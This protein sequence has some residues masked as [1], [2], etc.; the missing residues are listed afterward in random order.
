MRKLVHYFASLLILLAVTN[1]TQAQ[2]EDESLPF[3]IGT[4]TGGSSEGIY[5]S[6][7]SLKDGSIQKPKL[8]ATV[9]NPSFLTVHP[10]LDVLY[11]VSEVP[12]GDHQV[13]AFR[14]GENMELTEL[15]HSKAGGNGPCYI[16]TD[17][18]GNVVL[19]AN[20]GSG[21]VTS[22]QLDSEGAFSKIT[23]NIQHEG[24]SVHPRQKGPHAHCIQA[25]GSNAYVC[26]V[27]LGL[28]QVIVYKLNAKTGEISDTGNPLTVAGGNG[29]RHLAFHPDGKH[30]FVIH[31]LNCKL[32]TCS[33]DAESG[34]LKE[35]EVVSTLPGDFQKGFSTAEVLVHPNGKFVYGSNR[36]HHSIAAFRFDGGKLASIGHTS[37][38]G[39][40]PRNFRIDPTGRFLLAEN[41]GTDSIVVFEIDANTGKLSSTGHKISV[42]SPCCIKFR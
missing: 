13:I 34:E 37:T 3:F 27:D 22:I 42:G 12:E 31:E 10:K 40:T 6:S 21:S 19:V 39:E 15:S 5:A 2:N 1:V 4:Y 16:A 20:Y 14:I 35:L 30:A 17:Q 32:S 36:G 18:T 38:K 8:V 25:D 24:S 26:A 23:S 11:A 28:D 9:V 7:L 41:Q 33:W 29:P